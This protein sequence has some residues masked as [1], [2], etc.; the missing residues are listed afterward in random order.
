MVHL[1]PATLGQSARELAPLRR[2][3]NSHDKSTLGIH[4]RRLET[5]RLLQKEERT[6]EDQ[7]TVSALCEADGDLPQAKEHLP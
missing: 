6:K 7:A 4:E 1:S 3:T 2:I 5:K